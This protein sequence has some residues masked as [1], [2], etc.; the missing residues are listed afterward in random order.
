[1]KI[2]ASL[3]TAIE[4]REEWLLSDK[5]QVEPKE[6]HHTARLDEINWLRYFMTTIHEEEEPE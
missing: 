4:A 2:P 3:Y 5:R 1:M 6:S